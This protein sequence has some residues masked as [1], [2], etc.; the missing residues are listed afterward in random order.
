MITA[1]TL[2]FVVVCLCLQGVQSND[3][4]RRY[5]E[6]TVAE[7]LKRTVPAVRFQEEEPDVVS[8]EVSAGESE[9]AIAIIHT[10]DNQ[11]IDT[12]E[13][14]Q[15]VLDVAKAHD[16]IL[17]RQRLREKTLR[18]AAFEHELNIQ[19]L[20]RQR[21]A[22]LAHIRV[23]ADELAAAKAAAAAGTGGTSGS[24]GGESAA[25]GG[26]SAASGGESAAS[27]GESAAS[28]G[29]ESAASGGGESAAS[30]GE[31]AASGGGESAA[32]GGG[33]S[34]A[35]GGGESAASGGGESAA[36]GAGESA[37]RGGGAS[38]AQGASGESGTSG[39]G[40]GNETVTQSSTGETNSSSTGPSI[41]L[42]GYVDQD[43]FAG[44]QV[45]VSDSTAWN[46][47]W[48][49][50]IADESDPV[51]VLATTQPT[52]GY[53]TPDILPPPPDTGGSTAT[54]SSVQWLPVQTTTTS[55]A[56]PSVISW[57]WKQKLR[58]QLR[59]QHPMSPP[60]VDDEGNSFSLLQTHAEETTNSVD[61]FSPTRLAD[62]QSNLIAKLSRMDKTKPGWL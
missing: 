14:R 51:D 21:D 38:A 33:E 26:E 22:L 40:G 54:S 30:G 27:G 48:P 53:Y 28:G 46:V 57:R 32:S 43:P 39:A 3:G 10:Y 15:R 24:S 35:S 9:A 11:P 61:E 19:H 62:E 29:G 49:S 17:S 8:A 36:S 25:S 55:V 16:D 44:G 5:R 59:G 37:A 60:A 7:R 52:G 58:S 2:V 4:L 56:A 6:E 42:P 34:A 41:F 1:K 47:P 31:S 20:E 18:S 12:P 50:P 23:I 13:Q 45:F